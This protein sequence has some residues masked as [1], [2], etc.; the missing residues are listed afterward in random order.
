MF[1]PSPQNDNYWLILQGPEK[2]GREKIATGAP[3]ENLHQHTKEFSEFESRYGLHADPLYSRH[4]KENFIRGLDPRDQEMVFVDPHVLATP[5]LA[6]TNGDGFTDELV[7]P[8]SY[9]FD[10]FY[11]GDPHTM[12]NLGGLEQDELIHFVAGG[13]VVIDLNSGRIVA[14][15]L[16]GLTEASDSQPGYMLSTPTVVRMFPGVGGAVII[17]SMA[18]GQLNMMEASS[19]ESETGFPVSLDSM[20]AQV[21][22]AD[23]FQN[24]VLELIVGDNSGNMYCI[25]SH[26]KRLWEFEAYDSIQSGIRFADFDG[27]LKLDVIF[28][29]VYGSLWVLHGTSGTPFPGFPIRLNTHTQSPPLLMY[30]THTL[31]DRDSLAA[32]L[33]GM[34]QIFIVDLRTQCI[35]TIETESIMLNVLSGD[36]DPYNPGIE[37]LVVGM[38]GQVVCLSAGLRKMNSRQTALE[39]W[40]T[41]GTGHNRFVHMSNSIAVL[42]PGINETVL[43]LHG[44]SFTLEVQV[45]DNAARRSKEITVSIAIGRRYLLYNDTLPLYQQITTHTLTIPTPPVPMAAFLTTTFCTQHMQCWSTSHHARFNLRFRDSLQWFLCTPFLALG[46]ALLWL[47]RDENFEPL[48]GAGFSRKSL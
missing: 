36:V 26:G 3:P 13:I 32:I 15:K 27:D 35:N 46:V 44:N 41:D 33:P 28:V 31:S 6:D 1:L 30:L 38:D 11:Y 8:V 45:L 21:A 47:L 48:P 9:Y 34:S 2:Q 20:S 17:T 37:I 24:G 4:Q 23:M 29:T 12:I 22:V 18:T 5:T 25:D 19:L 43:N 40:S 14:Q 16:L 7:V 10:P 42:L 39:S